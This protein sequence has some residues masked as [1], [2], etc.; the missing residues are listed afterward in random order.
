QVVLAAAFD[1]P[2][3]ADNGA[4]AERRAE[5]AVEGFLVRLPALRRL[6]LLDLTASM[7]GD[8]AA[9][10]HAEIIFAYPG[11]EA[12]T[13]QRIAH[14]LWNLGVPLLPRIMTE[15]GHSKTGIDIHP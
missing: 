10:S 6:L 11:F 2:A 13:I 14:E 8:P 5:A 15:L 7:E 12:V 1:E 9:R 3:A 4:A